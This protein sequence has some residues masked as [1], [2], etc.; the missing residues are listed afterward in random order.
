MLK[1]KTLKGSFSLNGKGL[2]TGVNLTVT[3]N[4]APDNHGYKIQRIDLEGQPI[5]DAVA[6]NVGDTTR[7]TV[8][9]KN[10]IKSKYSRTCFGSSL[11]SWYR[12]LPDSGKRSRIPYSGRQCQSV[13]RKYTACR[14]RR[15]ECCQGL[16]YHKIKNR[17]QG[18]GNRI[19]HHCSSGR[20]FQCECT[21]LL[22]V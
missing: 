4:P 15:T 6:E 22:S 21:D 12:Q 13:C 14:N 18:R 2:H 11:C 8:L 9:M 7:G 19:F 1:Q 5:I 10:G 16:L 20:K 17:I 3:F